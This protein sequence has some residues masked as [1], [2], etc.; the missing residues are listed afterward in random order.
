MPD[1]LDYYILVLLTECIYLMVGKESVI[2]QGL[3]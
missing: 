1:T 3:K 2:F